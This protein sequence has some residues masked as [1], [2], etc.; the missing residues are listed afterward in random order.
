MTYFPWKSTNLN[1]NPY[2]KSKI[3]WVNANPLSDLAWNYDGPSTRNESLCRI[4]WGL[5]KY[6]GRHFIFPEHSLNPSTQND[7]KRGCQL[8]KMAYF[9]SFWSFS[10]SLFCFRHIVLFSCCSK[11]LQSLKGKKSTLSIPLGPSL[12]IRCYV[13]QLPVTFRMRIDAL[14]CLTNPR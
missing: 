1:L 11:Q 8:E 14:F 2:I 3:F 4:F 6:F 10:F 5:L 7:W 13:V 9:I 12:F